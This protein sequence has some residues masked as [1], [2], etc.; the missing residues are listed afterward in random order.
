MV[1]TW[2][3]PYWDRLGWKDPYGDQRHTARQKRYQ[4]ALKLRGL[5]TPH[6][7]AG[8][9]PVRSRAEISSRLEAAGTESPKLD[10]TATA[11]FKKGKVSVTAQ[12]SLLDKE[13]ELAKQVTLQ[14]V[15]FQR[16]VITDCTKGENEGRTLH[17]YYVVVASADP[18]AAS[19]AVEKALEFKLTAPKGVKADNLGIALLVEQPGTMQTLECWHL[20]LTEAK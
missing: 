18:V 6:L 8:N 15:L 5:Q 4:A 2:H 11:T 1:L 14:P 9:Q 10:V 12:L 20:P 16:K 3:V 17:E 7:F 13:F 19:K